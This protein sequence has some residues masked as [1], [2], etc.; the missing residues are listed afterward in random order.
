[1]SVARVF[2]KA[3]VSND[4]NLGKPCADLTDTELDYA[5]LIVRAAADFVFFF[6]YPEEQ[7]A[8]KA[9]F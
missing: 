1:M 5:V 7:D 4:L 2:A 6:R 9:R 3:D 8:V